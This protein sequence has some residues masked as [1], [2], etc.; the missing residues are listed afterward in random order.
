MHGIGV[1]VYG[2]GVRVYGI[3][4][5]QPEQVKNLETCEI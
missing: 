5:C 4:A 3:Q 1:W 2:I